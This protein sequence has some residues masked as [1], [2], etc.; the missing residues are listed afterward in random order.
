MPIK[1]LRSLLIAKTYDFAMKSTEKRCLAQWR[2]E[3]LALAHGDLLEIGAGTGINLCHY[4]E[5]ASS[6]TLSEPDPQMR[7]QLT[8]KIA[9]FKSRRITVIDCDAE[10]IDRPDNSFDTIVT[11]LVLCS[12]NCQSSSLKEIYRLL[13]PE[14][15]LLFMEHIISDQPSVQ[16]WQRRIEPFWSFFAGD[17]RLTRNTANAITKAGFIIEWLTEEPMLGAPAFVSRAIRG[18]AKKPPETEGFF[19]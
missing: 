10:A 14:G 13:R 8:R 6:I 1:K 12:V 19:N 2:K 4:P 17:C 5:H 9:E 16:T 3:I 7:K 18:V 15:V 11:T